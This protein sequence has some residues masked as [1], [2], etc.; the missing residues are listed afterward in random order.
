MIYLLDANVLITAA[1]SFYK[2]KRVP[3][4]WRW[5]RH[6]ADQGKVKLPQEIHG[7]I[8]KG[9]DELAR[10]VKEKSCK[11]ALMLNEITDP[12][13]LQ[14]VLDI[15][16]G[17]NL[18]DVEAAKIGKDPFLVAYAYNDSDRCVVTSEILQ[19]GKQRANTKL[20]DACRKVGVQ[21]ISSARFL[22]VLDFRT[23]WNP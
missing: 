6:H 7:E 3:E 12:K 8:S 14:L 10:W 1:T 23:D 2:M 4:Y 5:L 19:S 17:Q 20:P 18:T 15:S 11:D 21:C 9:S 22:D 16:Y 13:V